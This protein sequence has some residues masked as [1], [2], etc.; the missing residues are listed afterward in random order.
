MPSP[1]SLA[2]I[3]AA[4]RVLLA[5]ADEIAAACAMAHPT[6]VVDVVPNPEDDA[7]RIHHVARG[8]LPA[9]A[10][11]EGLGSLIIDPR[12]PAPLSTRSTVNKPDLPPRDDA[13]SGCGERVEGKRQDSERKRAVARV[14]LWLPC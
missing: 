13:G 12:A 2:A 7:V 5:H 3:A 11:Y 9:I 10:A 6:V 8:I 1:N 14:I 4:E